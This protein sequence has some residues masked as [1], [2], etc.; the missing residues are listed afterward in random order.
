[1]ASFELL[2]NFGFKEARMISVAITNIYVDRK[3]TPSKPLMDRFDIFAK[4]FRIPVNPLDKNGITMYQG[5]HPLYFGTD[6]GDW[7]ER[8]KLLGTIIYA[9]NLLHEHTHIRQ[10]RESLPLFSIWAEKCAISAEGRFLVRLMNSG[11]LTPIQEKGVLLLVQLKARTVYNYRNGTGISRDHGKY[12]DEG[13]PLKD[14][15]LHPED[16]TF[17]Y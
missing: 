13:S 5:R 14:Q 15:S 1:M 10:Y 8:D 7:V 9:G 12:L 2:D 11:R 4:K 17:G 6:H 3:R 16:F